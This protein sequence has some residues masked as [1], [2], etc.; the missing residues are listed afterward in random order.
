MRNAFLFVAFLLALSCELN[1]QSISAGT[2]IGTVAVNQSYDLTAQ[3]ADVAAHTILTPAL[4]A[5]YM[6]CGSISIDTAAGTSSTLPALRVT[7]KSA[8]DSASKIVVFTLTSTNNLT[9]TSSGGCSGPFIAA[10]GQAITVA[11]SGYASS[12]AAAMTFES[13]W[14]L[15][16]P[17]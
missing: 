3:A 7:F 11:T 9:S 14:Q 6:V 12:P 15:I 10:A 1:G 8:T 17:L 5:R 4:Q 16:G 2:P 13:H